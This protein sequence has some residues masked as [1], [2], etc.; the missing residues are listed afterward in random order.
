MREE[1]AILCYYSWWIWGARQHSIRNKRSG[2]ACH[3]RIM[4]PLLG[5]HTP[6]SSPHHL[7]RSDSTRVV[8]TTNLCMCVCVCVCVC[9]D[10]IE[11]PGLSSLRQ[12]AK[13]RADHM[14]ESD[15]FITN[16]NLTT[17]ALPH[18]RRR[19]IIISIGE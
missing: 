14:L 11:S 18:K 16:K 1:Y 19:K 10:D 3:L 15:G 7:K 5:I 13:R 4:H 6:L 9:I 2:E 17:L 8:K 12:G